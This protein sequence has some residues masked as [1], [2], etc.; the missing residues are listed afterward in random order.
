M[1]DRMVVYNTWRAIVMS[2]LEMALMDTYPF[3]E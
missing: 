3:A 1:N 2:C